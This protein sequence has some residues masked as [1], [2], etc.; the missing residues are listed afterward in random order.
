MGGESQSR[1]HRRKLMLE[2][3]RKDLQRN[4]LASP[5]PHDF[6][7]VLDQLKAGYN[8]PKIFRSCEI[9]GASEI[10]LVNIQPFDPAP[11]KGALRKV[12]ARFFQ[13]FSESYL[14]LSQ[15]GYTLFCLRS[16]CETQLHQANLPRRSAFILGN[17]GL[18]V[19]FELA[20][21]PDIGCLSIQQFGTTESLNVSIAASIV[22]YE[23]A[24][25]HPAAGSD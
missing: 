5:G 3:Y 4:R 1:K 20:D 7:I 22:M 25:Q 21:Y 8:V 18:G 2:R 16:D 13:H 17:E 15:R 24:R 14:D 19:S 23:Y 10:H 6:I 9:F 11:A 12:P